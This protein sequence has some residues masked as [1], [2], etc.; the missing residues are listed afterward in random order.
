[1]ASLWLD[2]ERRR[3]AAAL[4]SYWYE[5]RHRDDPDYWCRRR[6]SKRRWAKAHYEAGNHLTRQGS[7]E[8]AITA[9]DE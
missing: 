1:M 9:V 4:T 6:A 3:A 8:S 2:P 7:A 5:W